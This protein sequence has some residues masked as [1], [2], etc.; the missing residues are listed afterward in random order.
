V[1]GIFAL[2]PLLVWGLTGLN[3]EVPGFRDVWDFATGGYSPPQDNYTMEASENSGPP[4]T[5]GQAMQSAVEGFPG[6]R[7]TWVAMPSEDAEFYSIDLLD[8]GP[9]LWAHNAVCEGNRSVGVDA[10]D[11]D[12][13]RVFSASH[14]RCPTRSPTN[15]LS[16]HCTTAPLSTSIGGRCGSC[17]DLRPCC[18]R[19]PA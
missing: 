10:Y 19:S 13:V 7:V 18:C 5:L 12:N 8:A 11:A 3:F 9:Y 17:W 16:L 15:G 6:S 4:I 1:I 2:V 14:R